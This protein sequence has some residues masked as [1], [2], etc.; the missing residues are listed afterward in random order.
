MPFPRWSIHSLQH[1]PK[2][3][4]G[5]IEKTLKLN[6]IG[7]TFI[8]F[9]NQELR[10]RKLIMD[11]GGSTLRLI[12]EVVEELTEQTRNSSAQ[13]ERGKGALNYFEKGL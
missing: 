12:A 8:H 9:D 4:N 1:Q 6:P 2:L 7:E 5:G 3:E 13:V 10:E 11:Y